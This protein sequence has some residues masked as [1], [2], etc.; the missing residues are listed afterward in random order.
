MC[1][2]SWDVS[3]AGYWTGAHLL[4]FTESFLLHHHSSP[5][6]S[7]PVLSCDRLVPVCP[8]LGCWMLQHLQVSEFW[9]L[10]GR[11]EEPACVGGS[12]PRAP[13]GEKG[14]FREEHGFLSALA[15]EEHLQQ[16]R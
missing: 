14:L 16:L 1:V 10:L 9:L 3:T 5:F 11:A 6:G 8:A 4:D 13:W 15:D 7:F 12:G 2:K